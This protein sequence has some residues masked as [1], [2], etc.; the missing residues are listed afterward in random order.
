MHVTCIVYQLPYTRYPLNNGEATCLDEVYV[1]YFGSDKHVNDCVSYKPNV[2][3]I[4][5]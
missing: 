5:A 1:T 4:Y 3:V 2:T